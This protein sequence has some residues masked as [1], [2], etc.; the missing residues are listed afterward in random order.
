MSPPTSTQKLA[1]ALAFVAA[2]LSLTAAAIRFWGRGEFAVTPL[3]GGLVMLAFGV[4]G[5][6][7]LTNPD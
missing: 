3:I 7:R 1:V 4:A 6:R 2:A 5:Y